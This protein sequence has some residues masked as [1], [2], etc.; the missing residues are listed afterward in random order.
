MARNKMRR[1]VSKCQAYKARSTREQ[2]KK[3]R[4]TKHISKHDND[5]VAK[6]SLK[7]IGIK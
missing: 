1:N 7:S 4:L 6:D 2:N 3:R 5:I